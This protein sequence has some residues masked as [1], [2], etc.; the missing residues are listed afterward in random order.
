MEKKRE[1]AWKLLTEYV[2]EES[3]RKHCLSVEAAMRAFA[4]KFGEDEDRWA[5]TGLLHDFDYEKY[6]N[7]HPMQGSEILK[8]EGWPE[9]VIIAI[10]GHNTKSGVPRGSLMAKCLFAVDELTGM[11]MATAYVRPTKLEG[12]TPK[13]VKKNL[14]KKGFAAAISRE[15]IDQGIEELGEDKD[16]VIGIIIK[17]MQG[18][19]KE[20]GF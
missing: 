4:K 7:N 18:I 12:M 6:P 1:D 19:K 2:K 17:A 20:L 9:D 11:V 8:A 16:E 3:L 14:K 13:S 10:L 15:E 5:I